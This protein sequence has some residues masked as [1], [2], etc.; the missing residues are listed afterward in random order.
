[1]P[2][3]KT[4]RASKELYIRLNNHPHVTYF[5]V[6]IQMNESLIAKLALCTL[7]NPGLEHHRQ[8]SCSTVEKL[9]R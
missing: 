6:S 4:T 1:M 5:V 7:T 3:L 8:D 2:C 9:W